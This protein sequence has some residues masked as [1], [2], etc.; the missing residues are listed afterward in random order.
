[1]IGANVERKGGWGTPPGRGD[2][3]D[4]LTLER[5]GYDPWGQS[6]KIREWGEKEKRFEEFSGDDPPKK[7]LGGS[8]I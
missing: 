5:G 7:K 1:L 4:K 8:G 2:C 6:G 3:G